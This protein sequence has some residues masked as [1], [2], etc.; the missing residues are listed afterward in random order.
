MH[1]AETIHTAKSLLLWRISD[2]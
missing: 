2:R 1:L